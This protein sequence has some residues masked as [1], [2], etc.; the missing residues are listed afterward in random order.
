MENG[1]FQPIL[2]QTDWSDKDFITRLDE[3]GLAVLEAR[4]KRLD[5]W[6][7][8]FLPEGDGPA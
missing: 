2:L 5:E 6:A 4:E 1:D 8:R 3:A 7:S